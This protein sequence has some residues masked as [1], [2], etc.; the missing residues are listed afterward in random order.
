MSG[1]SATFGIAWNMMVERTERFVHQ[2]DGG[3][4]DQRAYDADALLHAARQLARITVLESRQAYP[5][6]EVERALLHLGLVETLH[7]GRGITLPSTLRQGNS[8]GD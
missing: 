2:Q 3:V 6:D 1:T 4:V 8:T 5:A 7:I